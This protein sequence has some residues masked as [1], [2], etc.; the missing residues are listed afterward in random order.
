M[1]KQE[2]TLEALWPQF[3]LDSAQS[4][5]PISLSPT[6]P[7]RLHNSLIQD[8]VRAIYKT[9]IRLR[10][11]GDQ[12]QQL[13][14]IIVQEYDKLDFCLAF[15]VPYPFFQLPVQTL[16]DGQVVSAALSRDMSQAEVYEWLN[17][18]ILRPPT[19]GMGVLKVE[20]GPDAAAVLGLLLESLPHRSARARQK[21]MFPMRW[22][23]KA[24]MATN[25]YD[26]FIAYWISFNAIYETY[27]K[28]STKELRAVQ[29]CL[30]K[31]VRPRKA[32]SLVHNHRSLFDFMANT[33]IVHHPPSG[34]SRPVAAE[35]QAGLSKPKPDYKEIISRA[36][37]VL[38]AVRC[39][40][41]HGDY[42]FDDPAN[43][44]TIRTASK[45]LFEMLCVVFAYKI[46]G[47]QLPPLTPRRRINFHFPV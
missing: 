1:S 47:K 38:Y 34:K 17:L 41:F 3:K 14:A 7:L 35:L 4:Y 18:P 15:I 24:A 32:R 2:L 28:A 37:A 33:G 8:C 31:M 20:L 5:G 39:N 11:R 16:L 40:L 26:R 46:L 21:L 44:D 42:N 30:A 23:S 45:M 12:Q 25:P 10:V 27:R 29:D 6:S 9:R 13:Q 22:F 36:G 43:I 19:R